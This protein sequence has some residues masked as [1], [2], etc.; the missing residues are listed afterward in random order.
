MLEDAVPRTQRP[1]RGL[2]VSILQ[3]LAASPGQFLASLLFVALS[4]A[5]LL[6]LFRWSVVD[7]TWSGSA[8]QCREAG[9]ACWAFLR[10]KFRFILLGFY[11]SAAQ[12][13]AIAATLIVMGLA[14]VT[15][16]PRFWRRGLVVAWPI[17]IG[18]AA[19][20]MGGWLGGTPVST[21]QWGGLPLTLFLAV[22]GFAAAF[23]LGI[24]LAIARRSQMLVLRW[25]AI[26]FIEL[27]R[28]VPL[29]AVLYF[30]TLLLPLML[31]AGSTVD[32]LL[33]AQ[34]AFVLFVSAYMAEIVRAGLQA[35]PSGQYEA[36]M[37]LGMDWRRMMQLVVLPQALRTVIPAFVTLG[38]GIFLDT[39]LVT[40]IGLFDLLNTARAA[41][42]DAA[43]LGFYYEAYAF[44]AAIYFTFSYLSSRYSLWLEGYLRPATRSSVS[45]GS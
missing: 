37:A 28:G 8:E 33:R 42:T 17:V 22:V 9:G 3:R 5:V 34:T 26:A 6:P 39:T 4:V 2:V 31:P 24:V 13:Q 36:S 45:P 21:Q 25:L 16:L 44:A 1:A 15:M 12:L 23:P 41:A 27:M 11:P 7:A 32:K 38:I 35:V 40:V 29:I 10:E 14:V 30:S 18:L 19:A 43:W 20:I